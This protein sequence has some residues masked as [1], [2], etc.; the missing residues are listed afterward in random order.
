[1]DRDGS[2]NRKTRSG[3]AEVCDK[4]KVLRVPRRVSENARDPRKPLADGSATNQARTVKAA[5]QA[6]RWSLLLEGRS[7]MY[8]EVCC[9]LR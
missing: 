9:Q 1:M 8:V 3:M 4:V 6:A 5:K 7:R 2:I